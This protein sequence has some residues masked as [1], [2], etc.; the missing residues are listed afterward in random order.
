LT[1]GDNQDS[2]REKQHFWTSRGISGVP[3]MVFAGKYLTTGAQ[4]V[5]T[6]AN[7]LKQCLEEAA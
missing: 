5:E 7:I 1:S 2:V 3:S 6:Y 4:G